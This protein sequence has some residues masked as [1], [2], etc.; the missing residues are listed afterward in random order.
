VVVDLIG[1]ITPEDGPTGR[2]HSA[3]IAW[4]AGKQRVAGSW[5]GTL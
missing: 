3:G 2:I 1:V 5:V 4:R